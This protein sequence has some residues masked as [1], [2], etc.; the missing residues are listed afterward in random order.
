MRL[1][2]Q[3]THSNRLASLLQKSAMSSLHGAWPD[4]TDGGVHYAGFYV[5]VGA[6]MPAVLFETSY[7]SNASEETRLASDDYQQRLA[8]AIAN[9]IK[10][11]REGH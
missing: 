10:A 4:A 11:Y 3:A 1:A 9:A 6:R 7:V 5:L 2:D 8:E